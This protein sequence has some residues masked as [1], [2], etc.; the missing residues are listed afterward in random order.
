M[1]GPTESGHP[2]DWLAQL[3]TEL[4]EMAD[5]TRRIRELPSSRAQQARA[6]M[7]ELGL[8]EAEYHAGQ[9]LAAANG[10]SVE[11]ADVTA[12]LD[13][14]YIDLGRVGIPTDQDLGWEAGL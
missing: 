5:T 3:D 14:S 8:T 4:G 10:G 6:A 12:E 1:T 9:T 13:A 11:I 2:A 7:Q